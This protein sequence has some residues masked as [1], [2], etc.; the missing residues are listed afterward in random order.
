[1]RYLLSRHSLTAIAAGVV[2]AGRG[3]YALASSIG[4]TIT[5]CVSHKDGTLYK[6]R[7]CQG[8]R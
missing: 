8:S 7:Q 2:A 5:D 6:A 3:A 1:M 4:G